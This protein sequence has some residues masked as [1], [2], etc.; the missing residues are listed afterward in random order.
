MKKLLIIILCLTLVFVLSACESEKESKESSETENSAETTTPPGYHS[1]NTTMTTNEIYST[2]PYASFIPSKE[3]MASAGI[4]NATNYLLG[5][6]DA[7]NP[8]TCLNTTWKTPTSGI[9]FYITVLH[10]NC[11]YGYGAN[12]SDNTPQ[13]LTLDVLENAFASNSN[14]YEVTVQVGDYV[15]T[16]TC[17]RNV[18]ITAEGLY[19]LITSAPCF[20]TAE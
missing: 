13:T 6:P 14:K 3:A 5:E 2:E 7:E 12:S 20:N 16:Y 9:D 1:L 8:W 17:S 11:Q 19:A 18:D 15:A 4:T 10:T